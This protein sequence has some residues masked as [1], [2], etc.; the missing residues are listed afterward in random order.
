MG[1]EAQ[2]KDSGSGSSNDSRTE[3]FRIAGQQ[4]S[5]FWNLAA[6]GGSGLDGSPTEINR[7]GMLAQVPADAP[8][9][10]TITDGIIW[11]DEYLADG[12]HRT[13]NGLRTTTQDLQYKWNNPSEI[14]NREVVARTGGGSDTTTLSIAADKLGLEVNDLTTVTENLE[15]FGNI[16]TKTYTCGQPDEQ[17][18]T[19]GWEVDYDFRTTGKLT[20][21]TTS[22][23]SGLQAGELKRRVERS[24]PL[25]GGGWSEHTDSWQ[26]VP[27]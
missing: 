14:R 23:G 11:T 12:L 5:E 15:N 7:S 6:T 18:I 16:L 1:E 4:R 25:V 26:R 24:T 17:I 19:P 13:G 8:R 3:T 9:T 10:I 2:T 20:V 22:V 21:T 27:V